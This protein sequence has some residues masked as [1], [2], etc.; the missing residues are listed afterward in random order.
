L[1]QPGAPVV[2]GVETAEVGAD[3]LVRGEPL[4]VA[5]ARVPR[6]HEAFRRQHVDGVVDHAVDQQA[7]LLFAAAQG[8]ARELLVADVARDLGE[9]E[10][11]PFVVE[12]RV[13]DD[14]RPEMGAV[15]ADAPPFRF[16][17]TL[18]Q[19]RGE[20]PF[21]HAGGA[22]RGRVEPG[23]MLAEDFGLRIS[24]EAPRAGVPASHRAVGVEHIDRV[25]GDALDQQLHAALGRDIGSHGRQTSN[26]TLS[27][28]TFLKYSCT[29]EMFILSMARLHVRY[30]LP[31][32]QP[33]RSATIP[34][35][36][37]VENRHPG[38]PAR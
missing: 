35:S 16:V 6:R 20:R 15:L 11:L 32:R 30:D 23:E 25:V 31:K 21:R 1:R 24:L 33:G 29:M 27:T 9:A 7:E 14:R 36:I 13:D 2:L 4:D 5:G 38:R 17:A 8:F 28:I 26:A 37:N 34:A 19:C 12:D 3:H 22:V 10:Q 18:L